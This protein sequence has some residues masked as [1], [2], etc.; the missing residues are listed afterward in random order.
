VRIISWRR[1]YVIIKTISVQIILLFVSP[2]VNAASLQKPFNILPRGS[3][4]AGQT[5][6]LSGKTLA[7]FMEDR[8]GSPGQIH[9]S[10]KS[11]PLDT[12]PF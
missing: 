3:A 12:I 7:R 4:Q 9:R 6:R 8:V 2:P 10:I 5:G 1:A 11:L